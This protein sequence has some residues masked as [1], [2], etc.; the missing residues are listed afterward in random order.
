MGNSRGRSNRVKGCQKQWPVIIDSGC[1]RKTGG[2]RGYVVSALALS[3]PLPGRRLEIDQWTK[4]AQAKKHAPDQMPARSIKV[5][6]DVLSLSRMGEKTSGANACVRGPRLVSCCKRKV[7]SRGWSTEFSDQLPLTMVSAL[8]WL[9]LSVPESAVSVP[10]PAVILCR[11]Q[12]WS[13]DT[14]W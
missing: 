9:D 10:A 1:A 6:Q 11:S 12:P 13:V 4:L 14:N 2:G 7:R 5:A 8:V 3:E